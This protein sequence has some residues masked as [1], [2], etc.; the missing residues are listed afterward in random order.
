MRTLLASP[1]LAFIYMSASPPDAPPLSDTTIGCFFRLFFWMAACIMRAIWS[2]A[3]PAPAATTISTGFVGSQASAG[4]M[5]S[6]VASATVDFTNVFICSILLGNSRCECVLRVYAARRSA[7]LLPARA[8]AKEGKRL[9]HAAGT[10]RDI[11]ERQA[12]LDA[13]QRPAQHEIVEPAQVADPEHAA[14][15]LAQAR[16]ERQV[17]AREDIA[18]QCVGVMAV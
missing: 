13:A 6:N 5:A 15:E 10:V 3:P 16:A 11:L 1:E 8:L 17:E 14:R 9:Q 2:E 7:S 4:P 18:A 12:H